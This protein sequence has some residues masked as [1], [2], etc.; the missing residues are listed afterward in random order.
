MKRGASLEIPSIRSYG[1][2][3]AHL[4]KGWDMAKLDTDA[5]LKSVNSRRDTYVS[6]LEEDFRQLQ[7]ALAPLREAE[8]AV[9]TAIHEAVGQW[10]TGYSGNAALTSRAA[11]RRSR[12]NMSDDDK[13]QAIIALVAQA[14]S[15]GTT[16]TAIAES[17]GVSS[18]T[19]AS[20]VAELIETGAVVTNGK[21]RRARRLLAA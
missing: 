21:E 2:D 19:V 17:L 18:A 10:P 14:G 20:T 16:N 12:T 9:A 13:R 1:Y 7:E 8:T 3:A 4:T 6:G 11:P 5:V 15:E